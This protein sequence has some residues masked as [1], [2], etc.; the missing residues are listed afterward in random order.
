[1]NMDK[2][3][4]IAINN[5]DD[6]DKAIIHHAVQTHLP[7]LDISGLKITN[8]MISRP[9]YRI[10]HILDVIESSAF[11]AK[12]QDMVRFKSYELNWSDSQLLI[13]GTSIDLSE[14]ERDLMIELL[15]AGN[16]GCTRDIL[17]NKIWGYK[18]DLETHALETQIYRLRQKIEVSPDKPARLITIDNGYKLV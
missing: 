18:A 13:D 12:F 14:R 6:L 4:D 5:A 11:K 7:H 3:F 10:G 2:D 9:P 8:N 17:L 1:M 16:N 15:N